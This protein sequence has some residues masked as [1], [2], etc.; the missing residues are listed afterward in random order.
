MTTAQQR[1]Q[2][3]RD[4]FQQLL[5]RS[6]V[7]PDSNMAWLYRL[8]DDAKRAIKTLPTLGSKQEAW[9]YNRVN[10]IFDI[11]FDSS[12]DFDN[13][14][15]EPDINDYLLP[16]FDS[17]RLVFINGHCATKLS[18]IKQ[19]P[20]GVTLGSVKAGLRSMP[21]K[22]IHWFDRN[23]QHNEYMFT[24]LNNALF[25]D[26]VYLHLDRSVHLDRP[27]EVIYLNNNHSQ[28]AQYAG[29][30][31]QTRTII[32]LDVGASA[33]LVERFINGSGTGNNETYFYNNV[34]EISL[35][36]DAE[37]NHCRVQDESRQAYHLSSLYVTQKK[38]S[39]YHSSNLAFGGAWARTE[40]KVDFRAEA[41][42]CDLNGLYAVDNQQLIDFH[43]DV[44]HRAESCRSREHFKGILYGKGRA[45]FDGRILVDKQAQ[46]SDA[47]LIN[48]NLLLVAD[49]E[50][51]T[52]PQL[53]I[54]ADNVKCSHGTTVGKLDQQQMFYLRSRGIA[55]N[56]ARKILC[57]G[58]AAEIIDDIAL[59]E[60]QK[61]VAE[62]LMH[63]LNKNDPGAG[64]HDGY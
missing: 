22:M 35:A 17:Y 45:V 47:A 63:A 52:K 28:S 32:S 51:D 43:L 4:W 26:G 25:N 23:H 10:D 12:S 13:D 57:Q 37:L 20:E 3:Q 59:P 19:L 33:T 58:Y 60:L 64:G 16:A 1:Q 62:K 41:A 29:S 34:S 36:D 24:A 40:Y 9:R 38:H 27:V 5:T 49:A 2:Q 48:D 46:F 7:S 50:I 11:N 8:R 55:E 31:I 6:D 61:H 56:E 42:I 14:I 44:Q 21:E 18:D 53:E 15:I 54:Y 39:A 30:M